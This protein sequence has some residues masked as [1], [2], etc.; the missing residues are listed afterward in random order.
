MSDKLPKLCT[1]DEA[2]LLRSVAL[3]VSISD[4]G[5]PQFQSI[6]FGQECDDTHTKKRND[7]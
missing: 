3:Q 1:C 6:E 4:V 2:N 7:G 5:I